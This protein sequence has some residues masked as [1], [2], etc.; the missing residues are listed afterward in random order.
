MNESTSYNVCIVDDDPFLLDMYN[1]KFQQAG[2]QVMCF[3]DGEEALTALRTSGA[4]DAVLLDIIMPKLNGY[5]ILRTI[6]E[7]NLCNDKTS[8]VILS[9]QG[10]DKDIE[11]AEAF[12]IDGYMVKANTLPSEVL[13][14][15]TRII[16]KK[17]HG[18]E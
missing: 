8:I 13:E 1:L 3:T 9:N 18:S 12:G 16:E 10:Q 17:Q 7:E 15:V 11:K 4:Q 5:D 2:H 6:R 14:Q